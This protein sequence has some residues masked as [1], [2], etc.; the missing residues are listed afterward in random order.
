MITTINLNPCIDK[1]IFISK[2][3]YGAL[4]R[5]L[6]TRIDAS[7]KAINVGIAVKRIGKKVECLGFNY[8]ENGKELEQ[9]LKDHH[10]DC[11]FVWVDGK[12]RTNT[13]ILDLDTQILTE[14][15]EYGDEVTQDDVRQL[16]E[17]VRRHAAKSNTIVIGGSAPPG[18]SKSIYRELITELS[19]FPVKIILDAERDLLI[20]GIK[21]KPYLIK[22]N[23]FELETAFGIKC[24][25]RKDVY[26][27]AK[28]VI[29]QGVEV[30]CVSLGADGAMIC[31]AQ[32]AYYSPGLK[33]DVKGVQG[34]GDS[35]VAGICAAIEE[36]LPLPELLRYGMAASAGSLVLEGTQMCERKGFEKF[37]TQVQIEKV[38]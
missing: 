30:V 11:E 27:A 10:I 12:L 13:K 37:L 33:L 32:E 6:D 1:S 8:G 19:D 29:R 38:E 35:M 22:P 23:L 5:V 14:L 26:R 2:F 24:N 31:S 28:E 7:G 36:E 3:K 18:V 25:S 20:K 34:A 4:N 9:T 15:N 17:V 21:A 16:K